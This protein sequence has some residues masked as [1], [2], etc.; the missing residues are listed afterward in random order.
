MSEECELESNG[1][2]HNYPQYSP[3]SKCVAN[4]CMQF[5]LSF[6]SQHSPPPEKTPPKPPPGLWCKTLP[7]QTASAPD[8]PGTAAAT[9]LPGSSS[10]GARGARCWSR[11]GPR[12]RPPGG[13]WRQTRWHPKRPGKAGWHCKSKTQWWLQILSIFWNLQKIIWEK[14]WPKLWCP[15]ISELFKLKFAYTLIWLEWYNG[16]K[17]ESHSSLHILW[18]SYKGLDSQTSRGA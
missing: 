12:R 8:A 17:C 6:S 4:I 13:H 1:E 5:L 18:P 9:S 14:P 11:P 10:R 15:W 3:T 7:L 2:V 16:S